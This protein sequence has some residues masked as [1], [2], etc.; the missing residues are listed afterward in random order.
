MLDWCHESLMLTIWRCGVLSFCLSPSFSVYYIQLFSVNI[1]FLRIFP[2]VA[3]TGHV[4]SCMNEW[5]GIVFSLLQLHWIFDLNNIRNSVQWQHTLTLEGKKKY[6]YSDM[7]T[8]FFRLCA[9][10]LC[11][12]S[13][14]ISFFLFCFCVSKLCVIHRWCLWL[15]MVIRFFP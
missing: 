11:F 6:L 10:L 2:V 4:L 3:S 8:Y 15:R 5:I 12:E 9:V 13:Y 14:F 7:E 1:R